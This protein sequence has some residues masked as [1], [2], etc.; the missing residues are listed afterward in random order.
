MHQSTTVLFMANLFTILHVY[1][2]TKRSTLPLDHCML[3]IKLSSA[4]TGKKTLLTNKMIQ[5]IRT[6]D[7]ARMAKY[8]NVRSVTKTKVTPFMVHG[9]PL[10]VIAS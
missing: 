6:T 10:A 7:K 9:I 8:K 3:K 4:G 5:L 1:F 2:K